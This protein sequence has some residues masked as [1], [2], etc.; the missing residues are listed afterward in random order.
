MS[1]DAFQM[2][3]EL[4]AEIDQAHSM[5]AGMSGVAYAGGISSGPVS[6][7]TQIEPGSIPKESTLE[8]ARSGERPNPREVGGGTAGVQRRDTTSRDKDRDSWELHRRGSMKRDTPQ[9]MSP[10]PQLEIQRT[11][12]Q[13]IFLLS[14][15]LPTITAPTI[16]VIANSDQPRLPSRQA[17][18]PS[19]RMC[20]I[21]NHCARPPSSS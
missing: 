6:R 21:R 15:A 17:L 11:D 1:L 5:G 12:H 16:L 4:I 14:P 20:L 3:P 19:I 13:S 8:R 7:S 9:G 10:S 2:T 18:I